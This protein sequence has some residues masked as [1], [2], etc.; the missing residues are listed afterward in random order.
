M[1]S[2]HLLK[3]SAF[4]V[5]IGCEQGH[6]FAEAQAKVE[7]GDASEDSA[8]AD[9]IQSRGFD[10][11]GIDMKAALP[12]ED[13][14]ADADQYAIDTTN[15]VDAFDAVEIESDLADTS[16]DQSEP[17]TIEQDQSDTSDTPIAT[18]E[19]VVDISEPASETIVTEADQV[20][21]LFVETTS[22]KTEDAEVADTTDIADAMSDS[23]SDVF[24]VGVD[25]AFVDATADVATA[26][27]KD[28]EVASTETSETN[29]EIASEI[30]DE[31]D[32]QDVP[33]GASETSQKTED[34]DVADTADVFDAMSDSG[35]E[36]VLSVD[37]SETDSGPPNPCIGK[38]CDDGNLCTTDACDSVKLCVH[39]PL[40]AT[41]CDDG[42]ACTISDMCVAG[43][44]AAG[45]AT[46]FQENY[47]SVN[48]WNNGKGIDLIPDASWPVGW[49]HTGNWSLKCNT[50]PYGQGVVFQDCS[51]WY[52]EEN[53]IGE[54][55]MSHDLP[56]V[57]GSMARTF[58][59]DVQRIANDPMNSLKS[60]V[61]FL[62]T[63][64]TVL[65]DY[66]FTQFFSGTEYDPYA[67]VAIDVP[68]GAA[69]FQIWLNRSIEWEG[70]KG[71]KWW[72]YT[73]R[74]DN[75]SAK[76]A[77]PTA[78]ACFK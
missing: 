10:V 66:S 70:F 6:S 52:G 20:V 41:P 29:I 32:T 39:V 17:D 11:S 21:E 77:N 7:H 34:A 68:A 13:I 43:V 62:A 2:F 76:I 48:S 63:D 37:T 5:L 16:I 71:Q 28:L 14:L 74:F 27:I 26:E 24:V 36:V 33:N 51:M 73:E 31:T 60:G 25:A 9:V 46:F 65:L 19:V 4:V 50:F 56:S 1:R 30:F 61:R 47:D 15:V 40:S 3:I 38:N 55:S 42:N 67:H 59:I 72:G 58:T 57:A 53:S 49:T 22:E 44:C 18:A 54:I 75:L 69:K 35:V 8:L 64:G 78:P 12:E 45:S 23:G